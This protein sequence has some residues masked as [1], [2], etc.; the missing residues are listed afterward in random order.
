L[1]DPTIRFD[2]P[3]DPHAPP[4]RDVLHSG[5]VVAG[6]Y[7]LRARLGA[8]GVGTVYRAFDLELHEEVALKVLGAELSEDDTARERFRREVKLARRIADPGVC[9]VFDLGEGGGLRFLT[10]ELIEGESLRALLDRGPVPFERAASI[11]LDVAGGLAAAHAGGVLHR[12]LKPGNVMIRTDGRAVVVD[13]GLARSERGD[14][15][16]TGV[17][18][19]PRYMSPEQL[20]GKSLD[21]RS[22]VF[23]F[24]IL[25]YEL[26]TNE[27]PFGDG[28]EAEVSSAILRD[29]PRPPTGLS[30]ALV[31]VLERAL[32]KRPDDR[33]PS[34]AE[35]RD[36]LAP[37]LAGDRP[38]RR[39]RRWPW[40]AA[41]VVAAAATAAIAPRFWPRAAPRSAR[42][43][44][45]V[46]G[47]KDLSG[48]ADAA[49]VSTAAAEFVAVDLAAGEGLLTI[50]G[51]KVA[52]MREGLKLSAQESYTAETLERMGR[53]LGADYVVAG[54]YLDRGAR[55]R[56]DVRLQD[57]RTGESVAVVADEAPEDQLPELAARVAARLRARLGTS[58]P[59]AEDQAQAR[60]A[61]PQNPEALRLYAEG[62]ALQFRYQ[63]AEARAPLARAVA[64]EPGFALAHD[65]LG[66]VLRI[67]GE[68]RRAREEEKRA[69]DL[70]EHLSREQRLL[71]EGNYWYA[72]GKWERGLAS[73]QWLFEL[74]PDN[75]EYGLKVLRGQMRLRR[76]KAA[77]ATLAVCRKL[78]G[79]EEDARLDAEEAIIAY[80]ARDYER[81]IRAARS[82]I[83]RAEV[84]GAPG[85]AKNSHRIIAMTESAQGHTADALAAAKAY[86]RSAMAAND[87]ADVQRALRMMASY[88]LDLG[89]LAESRRTAEAAAALGTTL[90]PAFA[91]PGFTRTAEAALRL[92]DLAGAARAADT[93]VALTKDPEV[94]IGTVHEALALRAFAA[95]AAGDPAA[96]GDL[97]E[98]AHAYA[99]T[100]GDDQDSEL[101]QRDALCRAAVL[102]ATGDVVRAGQALA[103][104]IH[105]HTP[106]R[107]ERARLLLDAGDAVGAEASA[108]K[109]A[110][111]DRREGLAD[112]EALDGLV[113]AE[114]ALAQGKHARA[115]AAVAAARARAARTED[116]VLRIRAQVVGARVDAAAGRGGAALGALA[117]AI[118]A[119]ERAGLVEE[120]LDARLA[121]ARVELAD[122]R[123]EA[124]RAHLAAVAEDARGR[125]L[126]LWARK[127]RP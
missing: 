60:A 14:V 22:D 57:A 83:A 87:E 3:T 10:M 122:G 70:A 19:T 113:V 62:E 69:L 111:D 114:A 53:F 28:S 25:A 41:A 112:D 100:R 34:A 77:Y 56:L 39:R 120:A 55:V 58:S 17:A 6:R 47:F 103:G 65:R 21:V 61:L 73:F 15:S 101:H 42:P 121:L 52:L 109:I 64:L 99:A 89:D 104:D 116:A 102:R 1:A 13:F 51:E 76:H 115:E 50:G 108:E 94:Y 9:R 105:M 79:A 119:A 91:A 117:A 45:A 88:E 32:A 72:F 8:G 54:A 44:V 59:T 78:P 48:R 82:S 84:Q 20:R 16:V 12:D 107:Q 18:G 63:H 85:L 36:D 5:D 46:V 66:V 125:G 90:G 4:H 74:F 31:A 33:Y 86:Q 30:P 23:S 71:I 67:S 35:L 106:R 124:G 95:L 7:E 29:P 127:A 123:A 38:I 27:R 75:L 37:A 40:L 126:G 24:G 110:E 26:L 68:T 80:G 93:A 43:S 118:D 11:L 92:G 96:A 98:T 81:A 49:W 2:A 97:C